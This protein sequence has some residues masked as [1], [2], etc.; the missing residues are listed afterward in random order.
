[1]SM[2]KEVSDGMNEW[3][4]WMNEWNVCMNEWMDEY[5][6]TVHQPL[7]MKYHWRKEMFA[8][9]DSIPVLLD[10]HISN[11]DSLD[12]NMSH[13]SGSKTLLVYRS[14]YV[15]KNAGGPKT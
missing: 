11:T 8:W 9:R 6:E 14:L 13:I 1:M 5:K 10:H 7:Q 12:A 15:N 2:N 3:N 4:V